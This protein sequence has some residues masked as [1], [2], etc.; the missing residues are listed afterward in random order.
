MAD[1]RF[2][3]GILAMVLVFGMTVVGCDNGTTDKDEDGLN[4]TWI[5]SS[6]GLLA[7]IKFNN[8]NYET[9]TNGKAGIQATYTISGNR[10]TLKVSRIH[11]EYIGLMGYEVDSKWYSFSLELKMALMEYMTEE[12]TNDFVNQMFSQQTFEYSV[13]GNTLYITT[14]GETIT[15]TRK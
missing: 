8:G 11:G 9:F 13:N 10:I 1:K 5:T 4:G 2:W 6:M 3:L 7:E 14:M 15:Y 12:E